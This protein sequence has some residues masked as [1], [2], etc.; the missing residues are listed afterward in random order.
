MSTMVALLLQKA[1]SMAWRMVKCTSETRPFVVCSALSPKKWQGHSDPLNMGCTD[2]AP[3]RKQGH[4]GGD[5]RAEKR[6]H[7]FTCLVMRGPPTSPLFASWSWPRH[8]SLLV[9]SD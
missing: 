6:L 4:P 1:S 7:R 2:Q 8:T 9:G 3:H 5:P